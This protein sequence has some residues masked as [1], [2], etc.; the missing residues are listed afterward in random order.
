MRASEK[1]STLLGSDSLWAPRSPIYAT[2]LTVLTIVTGVM[3]SLFTGEIRSSFP[4]PLFYGQIPR[5]PVSLTATAFWTLVVLVSLMFFLREW[6]TERQRTAAQQKLDETIRTLPPRGFLRSFKEIHQRTQ[7][8]AML[9]LLEPDESPEVDRDAVSNA[10]RIVLSGIS[11]L[12]REFDGRDAR[13]AANIMIFRTPEQI[14]PGEFGQLVSEMRF[15]DL[16]LIQGMKATASLVGVRGVLHLRLDLSTATDVDPTDKD[17]LLVGPL[18]LPIPNSIR[19]EKG[20][21]VLPGAPLAFALR[22]LDAYANTQDMAK[23]CEREGDFSKTVCAELAD[24]FSEQSDSKIRSLVS[25]PI[26]FMQEEE[27]LGVLNLH[28]DGTELLGAQRAL[29]AF[30][31]LINPFTG[32]LAALLA[33]LR[34]LPPAGS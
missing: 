5:G 12:A 10:I 9:V 17:P 4:F 29:E 32:L 26:E 7:T 22:R 2:A 23:W 25:Y 1:V 15:V 33:K 18:V 14:E 30:V 34:E 24:Y 16:D 3:G 6:V 11:D 28:S 31:P 19:S 8:A 27:P 13:Y 20:Y 21:R